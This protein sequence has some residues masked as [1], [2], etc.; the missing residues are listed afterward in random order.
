[1]EESAIKAEIKREENGRLL[2]G[3]GL[4]SP[5][6]PKG[7][8]LKEFARDFYML[9]SDKEKEEYIAKVEEKRPGFAWE[10]AEGKAA[11]GI[12]LDPN[13]EPIELLV[14][15]LKSDAGNNGNTPGV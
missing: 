14:R 13:L 10:M 7:K 6:R 9:K 12:G 11:Q 1:M 2:P 4:I 5:G 8:T 15:V 3:H